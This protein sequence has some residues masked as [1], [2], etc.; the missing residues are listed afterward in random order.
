M[1]RNFLSIFTN[2]N[3][4]I[5][6]ISETSLRMSLIDLPFPVPITYD[7]SIFSEFSNNL[8]IAIATSS[9]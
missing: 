5:S 4:S 6:S 2:F 3:K 7:D 8:V 1:R 9:A